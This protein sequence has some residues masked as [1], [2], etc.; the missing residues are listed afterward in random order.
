MG[1]EIECDNCKD[2]RLD[3]R[4]NIYCKD[5]Y[6]KAFKNEEENEDLRIE[7]E[8]L[9]KELNDEQKYILE[10]EEEIRKLKLRILT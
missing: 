1:I 7:I 9:R 10:L 6:D 8:E 3:W 5:C 2:N 4:D